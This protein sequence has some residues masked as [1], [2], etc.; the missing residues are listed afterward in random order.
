MTSAAPLFGAEALGRYDEMFDRDGRDSPALASAWRA[1]F[2]AMDP[3]EFRNASTRRAAWC[4][5]T[6][7]P[8]TST[9]R[10]RGWGAPWQLDIA[11]FVVGAG[12]WAAIEAAVA[13]RARLA[14]AL[15]ARHLRRAAPGAR[16]GIVPPQLVLG[17]PQYLRALQGAARPDGVHVHLYSADL[18]R[19][20][21]GSWTVLASRP[22]RRPA[23]A[24]R[25]RTASSSARRF[26][27]LFVRARRATPGVVFPPLSRS[28]RRPHARRARAR[29]AADARPVQR[30]LLRARVP[31]A[32]SRFRTRRGRGSL[33]PR[34]AGVPANA[35]RPR[36]RIVI[37]RRL[38]SDFADPLE[39]APIRHSASRARRRRRAPATSSIANALGGGVVESPALDAVPA[40][41][42]RARCSREESARRA[43]FR[44]SGAARLGPRRRAARASAPASCATRSTPGRSFRAA[45]RPTWAAT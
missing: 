19:A 30:S 5:R 44:P 34:R 27:E 42:R 38:D 29:R 45:R 28:G 1:A 12:D 41:R 35:R 3:R 9:T 6:A 26:P 18:A 31:G 4:A 36:A 37:F 11:P 13:Q 7:S 16:A 39:C 21:D 22:T 14:N 8:T 24:T 15:L 17:H 10:P 20:S 2:A 23:W 40:Q 32:I 25:S 43:T 33:G